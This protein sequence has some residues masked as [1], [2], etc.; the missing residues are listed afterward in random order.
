[1]F[2]AHTHS[3][4]DAMDFLDRPDDLAVAIGQAAAGGTV[5]AWSLGSLLAHELV[6]ADRWPEGTTTLISL[7]PIFEFCRPRRGW[8]PAVIERMRRRLAEDR[9]AVLGEF[10]GRL[11]LPDAERERWLAAARR[12]NP[13]TL[14]RGL[15]V[16]ATRRAQPRPAPFIR[17]VAGKD[18]PIAPID[19]QEVAGFSATWYAGGHAPFLTDPA[20][21]RDAFLAGEPA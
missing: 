14:D 12:Y 17:L 10:G 15:E 20:C 2:P 8:R 5:V 4:V 13:A 6:A 18:D 1:M 7:C 11:G 9:E 21:V 16:L 19:P 3:F